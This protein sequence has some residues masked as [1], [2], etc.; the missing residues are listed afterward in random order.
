VQWFLI[1]GATSFLAGSL[2]CPP[3]LGNKYLI[4]KTYL[5]KQK[6]LMVAREFHD[7]RLV[8]GTALSLHRGHRESVDIDLFS[9]ALYDSIDFIAID[10]FLC[11]KYPY[12]DANS[13]K[14]IGIGKSYY[15][16]ESKDV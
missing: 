3:N 6:T 8:G 10:S 1:W 12:V 14:A 15:I 5:C 2:S 4:Y 11:K 16:G 7:F 9:D 13:Y